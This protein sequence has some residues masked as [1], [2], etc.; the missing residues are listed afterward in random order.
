VDPSTLS[1]KKQCRPFIIQFKRR[2]Q[3]DARRVKAI[4][5]RTSDDALKVL[6]GKSPF[7]QQR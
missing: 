7:Q 3:T 5:S 6:W 2:Q 4:L 1:D